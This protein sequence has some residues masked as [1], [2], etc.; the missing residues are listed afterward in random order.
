MWPSPNENESEVPLEE[1]AD[2]L[3]EMAEMAAAHGELDRQ[4]EGLADTAFVERDWSGLVN[5]ERVDQR[6]DS[7]L[8]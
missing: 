8:G 4:D 7:H 1:I 5:L 6:P 2:R 3:A